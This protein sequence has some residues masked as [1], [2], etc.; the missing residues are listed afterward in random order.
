MSMETMTL[1]DLPAQ[2]NAPSATRKPV[3]GRSG[4]YLTNPM[5]AL[6]GDGPQGRICHNCAHCVSLNY[7]DHI[8]HKCELRG[9]THGTGT[10][11]RLRWPTC[12]KYEQGF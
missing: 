10:D 1:F 9:I 12:G 4:A 5:L 6:Y 11:H 8:Y 3:K 7:H 2:T